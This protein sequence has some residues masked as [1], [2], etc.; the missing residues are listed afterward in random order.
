MFWFFFPSNRTYS[1]VEILIRSWFQV[2]VV[3]LNSC[4]PH[5]YCSF[6]SRWVSNSSL[7]VFSPQWYMKIIEEFI[8]IKKK[9]Q[10]GFLQ[11]KPTGLIHSAWLLNIYFFFFI[12]ES[13]WII[14][15]FFPQNYMKRERKVLQN[16]SYITCVP[17]AACDMTFDFFSSNDG[18]PFGAHLSLELHSFFFLWFGRKKKNNFSNRNML[19]PTRVLLCGH[20]GF[21]WI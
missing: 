18:A 17:L 19:V 20:A 10:L 9:I 12:Y 1:S 6:P 2:C 21:L 4:Y 8:V 11:G 3:P 13:M 15:S 7:L 14:M 16:V 5:V